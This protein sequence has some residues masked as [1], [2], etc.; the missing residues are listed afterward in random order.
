MSQKRRGGRPLLP[1]LPLLIK[2]RRRYLIVCG[3]VR[4]RLRQRDELRGQ[5]FPSGYDHC[6]GSAASSDACR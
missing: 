5:Y 3:T 4:L 1:L 6:T 2:L